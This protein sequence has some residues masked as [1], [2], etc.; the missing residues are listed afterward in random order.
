MAE[1]KRVITLPRTFLYEGLVLQDLDPASS[2][3]EII[4]MYA[5]HY[6]QLVS[7][8][9]EGPELTEDSL[10]YRVLTKMG[11]KGG[12][13]PTAKPDFVLMQSV[14]QSILA[15]QKD[16]DLHELPP[17]EALEVIG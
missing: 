8:G 17:S 6:P 2:P 10:Q 5:E 11:T 3:Q 15:P 7:A 16:E 12:Q 4:A 9:I 14:A 1:G 13:C